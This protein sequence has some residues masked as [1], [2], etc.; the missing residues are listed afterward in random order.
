MKIKVLW[1]K[2]HYIHKTFLFHGK[3]RPMKQKN[4]PRGCALA[5]SRNMSQATA[6]DARMCQSTFF[7][8]FLREKEIQ[9]NTVFFMKRKTETLFFGQTE[10]LHEQGKIKGREREGRRR[11]FACKLSKRR[12][13]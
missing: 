10:N 2:I 12:V 11:N 4:A 5:R 7:T 13:L 6:R 8:S 3:L 9:K 1:M